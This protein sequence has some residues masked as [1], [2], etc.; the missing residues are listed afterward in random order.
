MDYEAKKQGISRYYNKK[1]FGRIV[2]RNR[3]GISAQGKIRFAKLLGGLIF[4]KIASLRK[5]ILV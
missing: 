1:F 4:G 2:S 5:K 3:A